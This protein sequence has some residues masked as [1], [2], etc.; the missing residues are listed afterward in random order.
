M[1]TELLGTAGPFY[2][3]WLDS[4]TRNTSGLT[5]VLF[6]CILFVLCCQ[7][8]YV[9]H[10]LLNI[11]DQHFLSNFMIFVCFTYTV[12]I[13]TFDGVVTSSGYGNAEDKALYVLSSLA[14]SP[15]EK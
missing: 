4:G 13:K 3:S 7:T 14:V 6:E 10:D 2:R 12:P 5:S 8:A 11:I 9:V 15:Q 1:D